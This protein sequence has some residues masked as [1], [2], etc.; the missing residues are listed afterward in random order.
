MRAAGKLK[1]VIEIYS[2]EII[3]DEYG[4]E[5]ET[6][7][8]KCSTKPELRHYKGSR[9]IENS[10][11][12]HNYLKSFLVRYYVDVDDYDIIKWDGKY[13]RVI[14]IEPN[15]EFQYK[16]INAEKIND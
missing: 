16:T 14:D 8:L 9:N 10:E 5:V 6:K 2:N 3:K 13:Y 11:I 12:V 4:Q 1:E 15:R 7:V